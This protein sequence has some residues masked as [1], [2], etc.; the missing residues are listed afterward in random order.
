[1]LRRAGCKPQVV[2]W[3]SNSFTCDTCQ[4]HKRPQHRI[5]FVEWAGAEVIIVHVL[6]WGS[7]YQMADIIPNKNPE[8]VFRFFLKEW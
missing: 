1:M 8:T 6:D 5:V 3:V 4:R 7:R 2:K